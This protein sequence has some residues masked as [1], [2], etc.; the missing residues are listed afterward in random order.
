MGSRIADGFEYLRGIIPDD[1]PDPPLRLSYETEQRKRFFP[2]K[3]QQIEKFSPDTVLRL[4]RSA[5][6][7]FF[8]P[9]H[10]PVAPCKNT[11]FALLRKLSDLLSAADMNRGNY[12]FLSP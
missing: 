8:A 3:D 9:P 4:S 1:P 2:M 12:F 7:V 10:L 5:K 6:I 11:I